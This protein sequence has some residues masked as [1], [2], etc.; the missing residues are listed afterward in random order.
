MDEP[1]NLV[2][3]LDVSPSTDS[4]IKEIK[5]IATQIVENLRP[6]D[7]IMIVEFSADMK[8]LIDFTTDRKAIAKAIS[9]SQMDDGT[10]IYNA[11]SEL[12][13]KKLTLLNGPNSIVLLSDG[14]DTVSR[15]SNYLGSL[16]DAEQGNTNIFPVFFDTFNDPP[17][18]K[19]IGHLPP[20]MSASI[21]DSI[22]R[23]ASV[24]GPT[25][26]ESSLGILDLNQLIR[27]SV[28]RG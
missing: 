14:I 13:R 22:L 28:G 2:L 9:K 19:V 20:G 17:K 18:P 4:R 26:E 3:L 15:K 8:I 12:F 6:D 23:Q 10:A 27:L 7:K 11:V 21:S 25:K 16:M 1:L 5:N 24:H